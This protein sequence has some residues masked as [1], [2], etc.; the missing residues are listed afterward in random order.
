MSVISLA[1]LPVA[2]AGVFVV[3]LI[4]AWIEGREDRLYKANTQFKRRKGS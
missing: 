1:I 2:L 4:L 3:P